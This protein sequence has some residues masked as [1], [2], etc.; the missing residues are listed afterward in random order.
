MFLSLTIFA[1]PVA[2]GKDYYSIL[3]I[4][5][6]ADEKQIKQAYKKQAM[7]WHPDKHHSKKEKA[8]AKFQEIAEAYETLSNPEKRRIYDLGGE[9]AVK[10]HPSQ[11]NGKADAQSGTFGSQGPQMDPQMF[12]EVFMR[13]FGK[14]SGP[15]TGTDGQYFF[16]KSGMPEEDI[17]RGQFNA[18]GGFNSKAKSEPTQG[19][20]LFTSTAVQELD[21]ENHES[22]IEHLSRHDA[23]VLLLYASGGKSCPTACHQMKPEYV[24]LAELLRHK[25]TTPVVALQCKRRKGLCSRYAER[26]PTVVLLQN[27]LKEE[28]QVI[29][30]SS[31]TRASTMKTKIEDILTRR[32]GLRELKVDDV[33]TLTSVDPCNGQF[34]LLLLQRGKEATTQAAKKALETAA[35]LL[36][37]DPVKV[38]YLRADKHEHLASVFEFR[39]TWRFLGRFRRLPAVQVVLMRPKRGTFELF[40]GNIESPEALAEFAS[41][42]INR[43]GPLRSKFKEFS[44]PA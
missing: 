23:A 33:Q 41:N 11:G 1:T 31:A 37:K 4:P 28:E 26:F 35:K 44:M 25:H 21:F 29:S 8:T 43:G 9:E 22:Q 3:G 14:Q 17:P 40:E 34:C 5:K 16:F 10:G 38:F 7:K 36:K 15:H 39:D 20:P 42:A 27:D 18:G 6:K 12:E 19:G 13:M 2:A 30:E 32:Q 24:K